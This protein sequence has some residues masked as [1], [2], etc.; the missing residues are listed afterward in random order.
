MTNFR[1]TAQEQRQGGN[2]KKKQNQAEAHDCGKRITSGFA[3]GGTLHQLLKPGGHL[4]GRTATDNNKAEHV[5]LGPASEQTEALHDCRL[6]RN[7]G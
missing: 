2:K 4:T 6:K 1:D 5:R 7:S 3:A